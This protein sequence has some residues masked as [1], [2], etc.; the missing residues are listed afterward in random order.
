MSTATST[1][2]QTISAEVEFVTFWLDD[3]YIGVAIDQVQEINRNLNITPAPHAPACIRGVIN[4]RGEVV[5]VVDLRAILNLP[6][7]TIGPDTRNVIVRS[8]NEHVG[9]L[10]DRVAEV[11]MTRQ[12]SIEPPPANVGGVDGRFFTGVLKLKEE[13][14]VI[15]DVDEA[16]AID[17]VES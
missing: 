3:L 13:L 10:I 2:I 7:A 15:L 9:L 16:L 4:L 17:V 6:P 11:V 14:L 8:K 1:L 12:K 5:T